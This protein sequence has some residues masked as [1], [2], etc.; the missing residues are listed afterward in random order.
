MPSGRIKS[1]F[2]LED[3]EDKY[4]VERIRHKEDYELKDYNRYGQFPSYDPE[5]VLESFTERDENANRKFFSSKWAKI[6]Q[7][8][9]GQTMWVIGVYLLF[10]YT[11]QIFFVQGAVN[12]C[13][14]FGNGTALPD[15]MKDTYDKDPDTL[16][17]IACA[18][19]FAKFVTSWEKKQ[20][21]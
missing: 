7:N 10:Y 12:A 1:R 18:Q 3:H 15:P 20:K 13:G 8:I 9:V 6:K 17:T 21:R 11:V 16:S 5:V 4:T 2:F 19:K 14:W